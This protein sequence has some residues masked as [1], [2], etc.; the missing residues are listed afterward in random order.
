MNGTPDPVGM[1]N[2]IAMPVRSAATPKNTTTK[3]ANSNS[4]AIS[5][6][7]VTIQR[8]SSPTTD[9]SHPTCATLPAECGAGNGGSLHGTLVAFR[10]GCIRIEGEDHTCN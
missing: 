3:L 4:A 10:V 6:T 8:I 7:P 1:T 5:T 9:S 2:Q